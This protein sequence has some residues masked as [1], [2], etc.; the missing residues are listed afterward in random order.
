MEFK[1]GDIIKISNTGSSPMRPQ[2]RGVPL[3]VVGLYE[4]GLT[5]A[6]YEFVYFNPDSDEA[7]TIQINLT[8]FLTCKVEYI[9]T[10]DISL[11]CSNEEK[12]TEVVKKRY[13]EAEEKFAQMH[14]YTMHMHNYALSS[15]R[16]EMDNG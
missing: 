14:N 12:A 13:S 4:A 1:F 6:R 2:Y 10:I 5:T 15:E 11:M 8:S 16:S 7:H 3:L 9:G